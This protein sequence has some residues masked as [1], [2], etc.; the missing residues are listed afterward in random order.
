MKH[1]TAYTLMIY[2]FAYIYGIVVGV[3]YVV[4]ACNLSSLRDT[5]RGEEDT[6][7]E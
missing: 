7:G 4:A 5:W 1:Y 2:I 3:I 6:A